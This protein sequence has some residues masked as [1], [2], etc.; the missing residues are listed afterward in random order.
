M[1]PPKRSTPQLAW[2]AGRTAALRCWCMPEAL[3]DSHKM[4]LAEAQRLATQEITAKRRQIEER[5]AYEQALLKQQR[6]HS[7]MRGAADGETA[8]NFPPL[9]EA[10]RATTCCNDVHGLLADRSTGLAA[11]VCHP[12]GPLGGCL[13]DVCVS[14]VVSM[15][16][17]VGLTTLRLNFRSGSGIGRGH[18]PAEDVRGACAFLRSLE[19][20]PRKIVLIGHSYGSLVVADVADAIDDVAAFAMI[21]PPLGAASALFLFRDV[22]TRAAAS[23]KPKLAI[24]GDA[25]QFCTRRRFEAFAATLREP[26]TSH[27]L[28]DPG[29][30]DECCDTGCSHR[31]VQV[32]HHFNV[33]TRLELV[34]APWLAA[35]F[36]L[37]FA[38]LAASSG[39]VQ[40][41][42]VVQGC[43]VA[44]EEEDEVAKLKTCTDPLLRGHAH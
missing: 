40:P 20:P 16:G 27:V 36:G 26:R 3:S 30:P 2:A 15:L 23:S 24:I 31:H 7:F 13:N 38:Q 8:V 29:A 6:I 14:T 11:V 39:R 44:D 33:H 25:D 9:S 1:Q 32:V 35:T 18:A 5:A 22:T 37:P 19:A 34:L 43:I 17:G 10:H 12:W 4:L 21:A 28:S 41:M 42:P